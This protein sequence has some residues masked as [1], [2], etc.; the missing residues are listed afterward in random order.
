[1]MSLELWATY[2]VRDH[3]TPRSLATDILLFDRLVFP[4]PEVAHFPENTGPPDQQGPV[5]WTID[6]VEWA[7]WEEPRND[8][9]PAGQQRLLELLKPVV[10][11]VAWDKAHRE[12]WRKDAADLAAQ[13][14]PDYSFVATRTALT[15]DLP[16]YVQGVGAVGPAYRTLNDIEREL[17]ITYNG[18]SKQLPGGALPTVLGWEFFAPDDDKLSDEELLRETLGFVTGDQD[19]QRTRRSFL[20]WQ[21]KFLKSG[22]TDRES[23]ERAV[24]DM[25]ELLEANKT[26]T[27]RLKVRKVVKN[28][29]RV[30][31]A[32]VGMGLALA[33]IPGGLVA[34][35][36]GAFLSLGAIAVDEWFLKSAE[37][38]AQHGLPA[39]TAFVQATKRHFGWK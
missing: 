11:K 5:E 26:A 31:P 8:W 27:R 19:F 4:V 2:S 1:M 16:A 35:G 25:R 14:L 12:Q 34:A 9:N 10:R 36:V 3:Q 39:P 38:A 20:D 37:Q 6:P 22:K 28:A 17:G 13:G 33:M 21:Q 24:K 15:R 7:R 30:A 18:G 32:G 23:I 29:F